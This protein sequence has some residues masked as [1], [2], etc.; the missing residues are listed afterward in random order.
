MIKQSFC[1]GL[2]IWSK[3]LKEMV[4]LTFELTDYIKY[5]FIK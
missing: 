2:L 1:L 3:G 4:K 5:L